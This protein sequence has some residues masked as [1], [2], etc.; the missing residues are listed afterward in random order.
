L[1]LEHNTIAQLK[2]GSVFDLYDLIAYT[3]GAALVYIIDTKI[4][5]GL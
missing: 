5:R 1:G 3:I 4:L 2:L